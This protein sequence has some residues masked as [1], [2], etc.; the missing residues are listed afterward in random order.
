[1]RVKNFSIRLSLFLLKN[2]ISYRGGMGVDDKTLLVLLEEDPERGV[3]LLKD[4]Y[5]EHLRFAAAQRLDSPDDIQECVYDTLTDFYL[6][7][8]QFDGSR[9]SLRSYL[10][11]IADRKAIRKYRENQRQWLAAELSRME[12]GALMN[13]ERTEALRQAM[14]QLP[15]LDRRALE[16]KYFHGYTAREIAADLGMEHETVKKRLQRAL[17]KLQ[18]LMEE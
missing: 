13:W 10:I 6:Q 12:A 3:P 14:K 15:P 18:R 4:K 5:A 11:A 7:R 16:L 2:A 17:K 8:D 9:G 1:M